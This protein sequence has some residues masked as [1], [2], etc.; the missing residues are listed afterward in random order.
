MTTSTATQVQEAVNLTLPHAAIASKYG[1]P[2]LA[3]EAGQSLVSDNP[4]TNQVRSVVHTA[5]RADA[6]LL[7]TLQSACTTKGPTAAAVHVQA[8]PT[9][10]SCR[11]PKPQR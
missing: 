4:L 5:V 6:L 10:A 9:A 1:K 2:L 8:P 11:R 7:Q 3:Y